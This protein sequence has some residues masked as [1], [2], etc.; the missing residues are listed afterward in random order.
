MPESQPAEFGWIRKPPGAEACQP[1]ACRKAGRIFAPGGA[2]KENSVKRDTQ[3]HS[4]SS[5]ILLHVTSLP[6]P[7]G[8]G[9]LGPAAH[10]WVDALESAK[11]T[12][13]QILPLGP[14]GH[15][16]SPYQCYSAFAGNPMLISPEAL[17]GEGLLTPAAA[18]PPESPTGSVDFP[19]VREFKDRLLKEAWHAFR[20]GAARRLRAPFN[21]FR[22]AQAGWLHDYALF[23]AI[24]EESGAGSWTDWPQD[25]VHRQPAALRQTRERLEDAVR[26]QEFV[27]FLFFRQLETLR[28]HARTAGVKLIGDLPMFVSADSADVWANPELF[29]LDEC[30]RPRVVAGVPPDYFSKTGQRWG[31]P[32]YNWRAMKRDG[33]R[34][35]V[36]RLRATLQQVDLVRLDH[37][38]GFEAYW[39]VPARAQSAKRGR[40]VKAPG[41]EL[42][43]TL[44][45]ALGGLPFI[46]E[47]LGLI[48]P[49]VGALRD[50]F[51][52]PG[53]RVLQFAFG[54]GFDNPFLPHNYPRNSLVYTGTHD[55]DTTVGWYGS[56]SKEEQSR[57]RRYAACDGSDI[58]WE[59]IRLAWGSVADTAIAP[60]QD[61]LG[62]A[63]E[64][65]I[66]VPGTAS[67]NWG[68]RA[69]A[70]MVT[71]DRL[72]RLREL[73]ETYDRAPSVG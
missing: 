31:N 17:I 57:V 59:L 21:R 68:W 51:E 43:E 12:W 44:R 72:G 46:A 56:L 15:G 19:R 22:R 42:L 2:R 38:R 30:R 61:V 37:F 14:A 47:D 64:G 33:Y 18:Q 34:W 26:R 50:Q 39:E 67:G 55:N 6:G 23:M 65:R 41:A 9:D 29:L 28:R 5:G 36:Q 52:L 16:D 70:D 32:L 10:A 49:E 8:I 1:V 48:T 3:E 45:A 13:W 24:R 40:W 11:Q 62:L 54:G 7:Y 35:W 66:N 53:M 27:Q 69:T 63:R 4:R 71:H 58:S 20:E 60:L 73:T 25:L